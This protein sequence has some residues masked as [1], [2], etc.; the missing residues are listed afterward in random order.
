MYGWQPLQGANCMR[1]ADCSISRSR[2]DSL[3]TLEPAGYCPVVSGRQTHVP[4]VSHGEGADAVLQSASTL[5]TTVMGGMQAM[6]AFACGVVRSIAGG[7][8]S[9]QTMSS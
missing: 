4:D 9:W 8:R 5:Q 7:S 2:V 6:T 3:Q 1:A